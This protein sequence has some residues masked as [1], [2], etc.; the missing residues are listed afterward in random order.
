MAAE[1]VYSASTPGA[2]TSKAPLALIIVSA[3]SVLLTLYQW[4]E[5]YLMRVE[6]STPLCSFGASFNC[7]GVWNSNLAHTVHQVTTIPIVGWGMAWSLVALILGVVLHVQIKKGEST[8]LALTGLRL[9]AAVGA[10]GALVLLGYS[11]GIKIFCITCILFYVMVAV[12]AYLVFRKLSPAQ[13]QWAKAALLDGGLLL[14]SLGVLMVPG[15]KTPQENLVTAKLSDVSSVRVDQATAMQSPLGQFLASLPLPLQQAT[16]DGLFLYRQAPQMDMPTDPSRIIEGPADAPLRLLDWTDMR[17][18]HCKSLEAALKDVRKMVPAGAW[19]EEIRHFPLDQQCNPSIQ[20][21][22]GGVSC[23]AA[24]VQICY[25]GKPE[26]AQI[27]SEM[28]ATQETLSIDGVWAT[29]TAHGINRA[30]LEACVNAPE[31]QATLQQDIELALKY[32]LEGTP[33]VVINGR[34]TNAIPALIYALI[35]T[36]GRSDDP[37]F[38][39]LPPPSPNPEAH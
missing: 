14:I 7:A 31:T 29:G 15:M 34:K 24:K 33:L 35:V 25:K 1:P 6:G 4:I 36:E 12:I 8:D 18:G 9:L 11:I 23:L 32:G 20:S 19:S 13:P 10:L 30:D 37:G 5:L 16:S 28:F 27:R 3:L 26:L 22:R 17:C 2:T 39:V 21:D 38:G